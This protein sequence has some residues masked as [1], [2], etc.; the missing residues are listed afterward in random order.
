[1]K[2]KLGSLVVLC[3]LAGCGEPL[4]VPASP[5]WVDDVEPILHGNCFS[6]HGPTAN[7]APAVGQLRWDFWFNPSDPK[8]STLGIDT[9]DGFVPYPAEALKF[10][11]YVKMPL[12][13]R[14]P[15][16]PAD[17]LSD[18]DIQVLMKFAPAATR[19][20]R[21]NNAKPTAAW[22]VTG[23]SYV[24]SDADHEQVVGTIQC[25]GGQTAKI[26]NTGRHDVP[27]GSQRPCTLSLYDGQDLVTVMLN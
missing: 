6:C 21:A 27:M 11:L 24:V 19:G 7:P 12:A 25:G 15:P 22:V 13:L 10:P 26:L 4:P 1:M 18:R 8:L 2:Q 16:P 9:T 5:T 23:A 3:A 14:M 17:P 20:T